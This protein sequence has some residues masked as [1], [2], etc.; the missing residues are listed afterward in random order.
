MKTSRWKIFL[1]DFTQEGVQL[2]G[3]ALVAHFKIGYFPGQQPAQTA[4]AT[5]N[6]RKNIKSRRNQKTARR[7][8]HPT[9]KG[10]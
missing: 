3:G 8:S 2:G 7:A 4:A 6:Q 1:I 5:T 9:E 10:S